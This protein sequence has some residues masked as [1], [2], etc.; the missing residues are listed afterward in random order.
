MFALPLPRA[1][2]PPIPDYR[3]HEHSAVSFGADLGGSTRQR[4]LEQTTGYFAGFLGRFR[5]GHRD[6]P[7]YAPITSVR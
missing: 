6:E 2:S 5:Y 4:P 7:T 3:G 1:Y